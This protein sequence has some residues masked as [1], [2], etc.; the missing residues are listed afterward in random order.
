MRGSDGLLN[1]GIY[2]WQ[3]WLFHAVRCCTFVYIMHMVRELCHVLF[4]TPQQLRTHE[5]CAERIP[6]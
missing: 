5:V 4:T 3:Y 2:Q 1:F 6:A